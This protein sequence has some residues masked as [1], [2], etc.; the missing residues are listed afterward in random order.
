M[1][2]TS[3]LRPVAALATSSLLL[4]TAVMTGSAN[5]SR[6]QTVA[7]AVGAAT[8]CESPLPNTPTTGINLG[9]L[10]KRAE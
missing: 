7:G 3:A 10:F 9:P 1:N 5:E 2:K 6:Q 4:Y 8:S